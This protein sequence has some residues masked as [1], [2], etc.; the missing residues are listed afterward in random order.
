[1]RYV[2]L[3]VIAVTPR[4]MMNHWSGALGPVQR[5]CRERDLREGA[6]LGP[7]LGRSAACESQVRWTI[8]IPVVERQRSCNQALSIPSFARRGWALTHSLHAIEAGNI[9]LN[10][11][12][13]QS[14]RW[15]TR[16]R[17]YA[18][19]IKRGD[20]LL[21]RCD[22][23]IHASIAGYSACCWR[24]LILL[25]CHSF[26]WTTQAKTALDRPL[27]R[28]WLLVFLTYKDRLR[29]PLYRNIRG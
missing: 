17:E 14:I 10:I 25:C 18:G 26:V 3:T 6:G 8:L 9:G 28:T 19:M 12:F 16:R 15:L 22:A 29:V 11:H 4:G 2:L 21:L 24:P 7:T 1:V 20:T 13:G 23:V 5:D 27:T